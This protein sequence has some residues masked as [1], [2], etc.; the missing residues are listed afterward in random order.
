[1]HKKLYKLLKKIEGKMAWGLILA[2]AVG[3]GILKGV[4]KVGLKAFAAPLVL[5]VEGTEALICLAQGDVV[6]AGICLGSAAIDFATCGVAGAVMD[7]AE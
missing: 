2:K 1:M 6:G 7:T 3:K 5:V 4:A